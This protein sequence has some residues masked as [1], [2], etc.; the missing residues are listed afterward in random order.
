M[1]A[2]NKAA[3]DEEAYRQGEEESWGFQFIA[4][5]P[6]YARAEAHPVADAFDGGD[7]TA[8]NPYQIANAD[9]LARLASIS[10]IVRTSENYRESYAEKREL[11]KA[12]YILTADITWN[13]TADFSNWETQAPQYAWDPICMTDED[14]FSGVFDGNG[15]TIFGL[16]T[17]SIWEPTVRHMTGRS[18][19]FG[20]FGYASYLSSDEV[21]A[22]KNVS[23]QD[24]LFQLYNVAYDVGGIVGHMGSGRIENCH[25]NATILCDGANWV[26]GIVGNSFK[27]DIINCSFDGTIKGRHKIY[28]LAG[29]AAEASGAS[30]VKCTNNGILT[31][32]NDTMYLG[33]IVAEMTDSTETIIEQGDM[34]FT[35]SG[36]EVRSTTMIDS[37]IND[38]SIPFGGGIVGELLAFRS[39]VVI[40]NCANNGT[41][42]GE[43]GKLLGGIIGR[44][45]AYG[46]NPE[47]HPGFISKVTVENCV[48]TGNVVSESEGKLGGIIALAAYQ[49][50]A[51][52]SIMKCK[53]T[54]NV[55]CNSGELGGILGAAVM[56]SNSTIE[57]I[58]CENSASVTSAGGNTGGIVGDVC[59]ISEDTE[60]QFSIIQGKNSGYISGS[61]YGVGGILGGALGHHGGA[62]ERVTISACENTG[63]VQATLPCFIGGVVGYLPGNENTITVS[64]CMNDG[65]IKLTADEAWNKDGSVKSG[66]IYGVAGG[67]VGAAKFS[68]EISSCRSGGVFDID[69]KITEQVMTISDVALRFDDEPILPHIIGQ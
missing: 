32:T 42:G 12:H 34:S 40:R 35:V 44:L 23:V 6:E 43:K 18:A 22:I 65:T 11:M 51:E 4:E 53:N 3:S 41:I 69:D 2:S 10:N 64:A 46:D 20:L 26:G 8:E 28:D 30:I 39:D 38:A 25:T 47:S 36:T 63:T 31:P 59:L 50:G 17:V 62:G 48:N 14:S 33:G 19:A 5:I 21:G 66:D 49:D 58:D 54:G 1:D 60:R 7:G 57:L 13:D 61:G 29:I 27:T 9:Q 24:S 15:H 45:A 52:L 68:A 55:S 56:Y 67:I 16:Y 37:C